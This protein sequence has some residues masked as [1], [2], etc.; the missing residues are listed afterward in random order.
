[1]SPDIAYLFIAK[2]DYYYRIP[3]ILDVARIE[4]SKR[5]KNVRIFPISL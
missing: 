3:I 4:E 1:M 5:N 2:E